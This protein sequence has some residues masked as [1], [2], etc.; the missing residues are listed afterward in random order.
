MT[1]KAHNLLVSTGSPSRGGD[2]A[3]YVFDIKQPSSPTP[4]YSVFVSISVSMALS[5][6]VHSN[7]SPDFLLCSSGLIFALMVHSTIYLFMRVSFSPD[8]IPLVNWA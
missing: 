4:F 3:V 1:V 5:T 8:V 6:V 2:V 7:N